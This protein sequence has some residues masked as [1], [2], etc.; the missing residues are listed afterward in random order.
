MISQSTIVRGHS[1]SPGVDYLTWT[2]VVGG[3][4]AIA[5]YAAALSPAPNPDAV[6]AMTV[7]P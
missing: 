3:L 1:T 2:I 7:Q 6:I 5:I 4:L